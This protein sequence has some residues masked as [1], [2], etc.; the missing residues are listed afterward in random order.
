MIYLHVYQNLRDVKQQSK[1]LLYKNLSSYLQQKINDADISYNPN[2]KPSVKG[3][4]YSIS[5]SKNIV[6][7]AFSQEQEIGIDVEY[8]NC[9]RHFKA[10]AK[11]YYHLQEY[12]LME[13]LEP[14]Q[15][16]RLFYTLWSLKESVCKAEGG[17]LWYYLSDN[18]LHKNNLLT[19]KMNGM[20]LTT[21]TDIKGYSLALASYAD[22]AIKVVL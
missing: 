4:Y 10:L 19:K 18:Y 13:S 3:L 21:I 17:R 8:I 9:A 22:T 7:Q 11:R 20:D 1:K 2:G 5:H 14:E 16:C 15:A 12:S 6:V